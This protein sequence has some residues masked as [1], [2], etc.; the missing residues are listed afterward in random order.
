LSTSKRK[1]N[2]GQPNLG[3]QYIIKEFILNPD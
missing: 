1:T 3:N 2:L